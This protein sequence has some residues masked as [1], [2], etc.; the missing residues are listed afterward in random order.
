MASLPVLLCAR[1]GVGRYQ[2]RSRTRCNPDGLPLNLLTLDYSDLPAKADSSNAAPDTSETCWC[3][4][5]P[6]PAIMNLCPLRAA[7]GPPLT[8]PPHVASA[9]CDLSTW[10]HTRGSMY[11]PRNDNNT[12]LRY[13]HRFFQ[14][15]QHHAYPLTHSS[16]HRHRRR[17]CPGG[18]SALQPPVPSSTRMHSSIR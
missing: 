13:Q 9:F 5:S 17:R 7:R 8:T 10:Q 11:A 14:R 2:R 15:T 3:D 1:A 6:P 16:T 18:A 12:P 4:D